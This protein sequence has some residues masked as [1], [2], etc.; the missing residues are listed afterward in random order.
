ML[1]R[2]VGY[3]LLH[4]EDLEGLN[5]GASRLDAWE[6]LSAFGL[7]ER[8][9]AL[10]SGE[11]PSDLFEGRY[12][13]LGD[14]GRGAMG[15]VSRAFDTTLSR[16]V[17]LKR[18]LPE[19]AGSSAWDRFLREGRALARLDH[20]SCV[21]VYDFGISQTE[22]TPYMALQLVLGRSLRDRLGDSEPA[23]W[24]DV[25]RWGQQ[26]SEGLA[27]CHAVGLVH[28]DIKPA[29]ILL[30]RC[31]PSRALLAD[32]GIAFAAGEA[33]RLTKPG[34][35]IGTYLFCAPETLDTRSSEPNPRSDLYSLGLSLYVALTHVHP[36]EARSL[37]M[38]LEGMAR[39]IPPIQGLAPDVPDWLANAIH[40][41]LERKPERRFRDATELAYALSG[42][43]S[44]AH[45][46]VEASARDPGGGTGRGIGMRLL[47]A[48]GL[49]AAGAALGA[50]P[51]ALGSGG[52]ASP[53]AIAELSPS[54]TPSEGASPSPTPTPRG[55]AAPAPAQPLL[56]RLQGSEWLNTKDGSVLVQIPAGEFVMGS[57]DGLEN[58]RPRRSARCEAFLISRYEVTWAQYDAFCDATG[59]ERK[60][61]SVAAEQGEFGAGPN[62]PVFG[63]MP[64]EARAYCAWA[65]GRLPTEAEWEYAAR[66]R[67]GR[68]YPWPDGAKV[69]QPANVAD[70]TTI[71]AGVSKVYIDPTKGYSDG[72]AFTAPVGSFPEGLSPF[73]LADMAGNV[74]ELTSSEFEPGIPVLKGGGWSNSMYG[75]RTS[76]R[77]RNAPVA[78]FRIAMDLE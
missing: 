8:E 61:R 52:S 29:N 22:E 60:G 48:G 40:R 44:G 47:L 54:A 45:G 53:S 26:L 18:L 49:L 39:P 43:Q 74:I 46:L 50:I 20:P 6:I 70:E 34:G 35:F 13:I 38:L 57:D 75:A 5:E 21:R 64:E 42:G 27:A 68:R 7:G 66:G 30:E 73:G 36:Y 69:A 12:V 72:F 10:L 33:E 58:E 19:A 25:A 16:V 78:G 63:V 15:A 41:C 3:G 77:F 59:R 67:T 2:A 37:P 32:F 62:T 1:I 4:P 71:S 11:P 14:L 76:A 31:K 51:R 56:R 55:S 28:R 9:R 24:Q 65:K 23:S 17:A